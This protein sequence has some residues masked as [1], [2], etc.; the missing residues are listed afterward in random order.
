M[1]LNEGINKRLAELKMTRSDLVNKFDISWAT[2]SSI[3]QGK[4]ISAA[5][6]EKLAKALKWSIGDI[7]AILSKSPHPLR[8]EAEKPEGQH[9][10][11][12]TVDKL[13]K[14]VAEDHPNMVTKPAYTLVT[15]KKEESPVAAPDPE[16]EAP[17]TDMMFPPEDEE[18]LSEYDPAWAIERIAGRREYA[19][20]LKNLLVEVMAGAHLGMDS[21]DVLM[22]DFGK[23]VIDKLKE[24]L[25]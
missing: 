23:A 12:A 10:I 13:E 11:M 19:T 7:N 14:M 20:E 17:E 4:N 25:K 21:A 16:D 5:T 2:L 24:E 1:T 22:A 8:K 15:A 9:S 6:K 3:T 18:A